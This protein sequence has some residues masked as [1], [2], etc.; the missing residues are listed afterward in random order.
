MFISDSF[1][2][3]LYVIR[4]ENDTLTEL[5]Q[6]PAWVSPQ[7]I[8]V[9]AADSVLLYVADYRMGLY[10]IDPARREA[11]ALPYPENT[12]LMGID[13][14]YY[15][16]HSL[17]AVQNGVNPQRIIRAHL[18]PAGDRIEQIEV[19]E[20]NHPE[21]DEPTLGVISGNIFYYIANSQWGSTLDQQGQLRPESE[22][23]FPLVFKIDL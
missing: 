3:R 19:L 8:T 2:P 5:L 15:H 22:L 21:F 12:I 16:D 14:L 6:E 20:A 9:G 17:I 18:N 7:G 1:S 13:G 23:K 11:R 4:A 10:R